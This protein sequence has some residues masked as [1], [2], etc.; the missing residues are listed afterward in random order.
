MFKLILLL[1]THIYSYMFSTV[2]PPRVEYQENT[3][4]QDGGKLDLDWVHGVGLVHT[5]IP[6]LCEYMILVHK[7]HTWSHKAYVH[8]FKIQMKATP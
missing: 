5:A 3:K 7:T 4:A 1:C 6:K 2:H 8:D